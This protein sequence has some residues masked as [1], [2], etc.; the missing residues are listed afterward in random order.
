MPEDTPSLRTSP[1]DVKHLAV[2][3]VKIPSPRISERE[4]AP[5]SPQLAKRVL[6]GEGEDEIL[7][8]D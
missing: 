2:R 3:R 7:H 8:R 1:F 6:E 4:I 5:A